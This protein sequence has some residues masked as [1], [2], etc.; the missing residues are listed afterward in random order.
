[1]E[2]NSQLRFT[3][4]GI[5]A[6]DK[7][8]NSKFISVHLSEHLPFYEGDVTNDITNI[9]FKGKDH[10]GKEYKHTLQKGMTVKAEWKGSP[11]RITSPNV[12]KGETVEIYELGGEN[13]FFWA[14]TANNN[15]LR[16]AEAVTW[17]FNAS[18]TPVDSDEPPT[19]SNHYT[20]T[21]DG[22]DGHI[23]LATS[24]ANKEKAQYVMQMHGKEGHLSMSDNKGNLFQID[25][26]D[27]T[28]TIKNGSGSKVVMHG[29]IINIECSDQIVM[30]ATKVT[31]DGDLDVTG[32]T[33]LQSD[34]TA[35]KITA[36]NVTT[37]IL[38]AANTHHG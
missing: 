36:Q 18:G 21:I 23:T 25:S 14:E 38:H 8:E 5:V 32:K 34:T 19:A 1:M 33:N 22:K 6:A 20:A 37:A 10:H 30:K 26:A 31:I 24:L 2:I 3:S 13:R 7:N 4:L 17:A 11:N 27:G 16:R 12:R 35:T 9:E 28:V 15:H 29:G